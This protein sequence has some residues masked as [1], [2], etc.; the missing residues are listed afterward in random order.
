MMQEFSRRTHWNLEKTA[1]AAAL[2]R[3]RAGGRS[4][5][6]LTA[7]NPTTCGFQYDRAGILAELSRPECLEYEADPRGLPIARAAVVDYYADTAVTKISAEQIFLTTSTSEAY[8]YLFRLHC[9][10]GEEI[11]IAQ[12]SYPLFD[13]LADLDDVR[14]VPYPLFYD[15]GWQIDMAALTARITLRTRAVV[16]VH[17]NNPTGHFTSAAERRL[18]ERICEEHGLVLIIDEVFLD[19]A[20]DPADARERAC[21]SFSTGEHP[22]LT[23]VLSGLSKVAGLPQMK[24]AWIAAF[25]PEAVR[26]AAMSRLEVIADTFLSMNAPVQHALPYLLANRHGVQQQIRQRVAE[27]LGVLDRHLANA[28]AVSRLQIQGGWYAVLR[29]PALMSGD[30]L[31]IRA[32]EREGVVVHP[33]YFYGFDGDGW[34]VLSLLPPAVEFAEGVTGLLHSIA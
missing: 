25:G 33:G 34:L 3:L 17:P 30:A 9:D 23:Y 19:Y 21:A 12:P 10:P 13:F 22:V 24:A 2:E 4:L 18:L 14:L 5:F 32:M 11:L 20:L 31:A 6:D 16:V 1:Y 8:S 28:P 29:V 15:H 7:S 26:D 27:N